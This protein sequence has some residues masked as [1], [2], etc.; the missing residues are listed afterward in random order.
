MGMGQWQTGVVIG[1]GI[2][3]L[4]LALL[5]TTIVTTAAPAVARDFGGNALSLVPWLA[6]A[7]AL[8]ETVTQP[9]YGKLTDRH[10]PRRMLLVALSLFTLGSVACSLASSMDQLIAL[11]VVQGLGAAGLMSVTFV[12]FGH[13][14]AASDRGNGGGNAAAGVILAI[15]LILGPL[16]GGSI[17]QHI[18]WR[19]IFW[20]NLPVCVTVI[21]IMA[22]CLRL[23]T[24]RQSTERRQE[25]IDWAAA[26]LLAAAAG[27]LQ[28]TFTWGGNQFRWESWPIVLAALAGAASIAGFTVRQRVSLQPFFAPYL[29]HHKTLRSLS[30]LQ[31]A[32]GTGM[33]AGTI[34]LTLD[35]QLIHH[36]SPTRAGIQII[37]MALGVALGAAGGTAALKRAATLRPSLVAANALC[38]AA[39]L[40]LALTVTAN[41][42]LIVW[43]ALP[44]LGVGIGL[45]LGNELLIVQGTV[46]LRD[47]GTATTGVRFIET[48]GTSAGAAIFAAIFSHYTLHH[49][50]P[51]ALTTAITVIFAL[52]AAIMTI[53]TWIAHG[54]PAH[55]STTPNTQPAALD[56][57]GPGPRRSGTTH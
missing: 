26:A 13:L 11:R 32:V 7:Y 42:T 47:L 49:V 41:P 53:A 54:L 29:L 31:L 50:T 3:T 35:M 40:T 55:L 44:V 43:L 27:A 57:I 46:P 39:F 4:L 24:E 8:A 19:W 36:Y 10:G 16:V 6:V 45:G 37:P 5:D 9:L 15:G 52:G 20:V 51:G 14:R 25:P 30:L 34:Y 22:S 48:L 56:Q 33:A 12:L 38:A 2:A 21:V 23:P 1:G 18:D 28:L 17:V